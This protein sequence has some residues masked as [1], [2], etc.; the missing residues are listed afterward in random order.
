MAVAAPAVVEQGEASL[1]AGGTEA[2]KL[3]SRGG[4][5]WR[6]RLPVV[7]GVMAFVLAA[8]TVGSAS[9][10]HSKRLLGEGLTPATAQ[11]TPGAGPI[12][13]AWGRRLG[14]GTIE[15][16][17]V[18]VAVSGLSEVVEVAAGPVHSLALA[19]NGTVWAW[20]S[21]LVGALGNG[22]T[23]DST[24]P[25]QVSGL[26]EAVAIAAGEQSSYAVLKNGT[27]MA[28][29]FNLDGA[30]GDGSFEGPESCPPTYPCSRVPL[31]VSGL[32]EV[33]AIAADEGH[34]LALLKNGT[35]KAWG[36]NRWGQLGNGHTENTAAPVAVSGLSEVAGIGVGRLHSLAVLKSGAVEAWGSNEQGQLGDGTTSGPETCLALPCSTKPVAVSGLSE[37]SAVAGGGA[38]SLALLKNHTVKAWGRNESGEL[39]DGTTTNS[40]VPVPV[41]GLSE[42][43]GIAGG[44]GDSFARL[45]SGKAVGWGG[46]SE[47]SLGNGTNTSSS[48]PVAVDGLSEVTDISAG[49]S[50]SGIA[51]G[52]LA[53]LPTVTKVEPTDGP[54]TGGTAVT[55]TGTNF[56]GVTQVKFG[57]TNATSF[58]VN[59]ETSLTATSPAGVGIVDVT[60][61][62]TAGTSGTT[63]A[64]RFAY[65]PT[66]TKA[67]PNNGARMGGTTVTITGTNFTGATAVKFGATNATSFT[68][69]SAS[70]ITAVS[71]AGTGTVDVTVTTPGG[72]SAIGPADQFTYVAAVPTVTKVEP[73]SGPAA[74]GTSVTITGTNF[75]GAT[76]VKFGATNATSFT[77]N[78][79]TSISAVSPPGT[80]TVDVILTTP[81]GTSSTAN[82][83]R[84]TYGVTVTRVEPTS[85]RTAGGTSVTIAGTNFTGAT[86]V[87]FGATNATSFT[88]N[89]ATSITAV[90]PAG[91]GT[92]DV[93]VTTPEGTSAT[94][95]SDHFSY[96]RRFY[97][98]GV[99]AGASTQNVVQFGTIT[100]KSPFWGEIKCNLLV[101]A[102]VWNETER[103]LAS[104]DGWE[105]WGC[106]ATELR[107][108]TFVTA[109]TAVQLIERENTAK[110]RIPEAHRGEKTLPWPAHAVTTPEATSALKIGN[111]EKL[112]LEPVKFLVSAPEELFE[113]PYEGTLEPRIVNGTKN[114]LKPS[115]LEFEGEGGKTGFLKSP[116]IFGGKEP[117]ADLF[118]KGE[119]TL[120]GTSQQLVGAE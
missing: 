105:S 41:S 3:G 39:G 5:R 10:E 119:L 90:S 95:L 33:A 21:N 85:G 77:V 42:A 118:I 50:W 28:W 53:P 56:T 65:V 62:A 1:R 60:V 120:L 22:T 98:N 4:N 99:L 12:P 114:G 57:S 31:K 91:T 55:I 93:T 38:H 9:A 58:T 43:A 61:T 26:S 92:V 27:V 102:P 79:A 108:K 20:G 45:T 59:S 86:A 82:A 24:V 15:S 72:T 11:L 80:G 116:A 67:E 47:G 89:S 54:A 23:T 30:L 84:F 46:N 40:S 32:S 101:G 109:E 97:L 7:V 113:V 68:V 73:N 103:G 17:N 111:T 44:E 81:E 18:P 51:I 35:V 14:S 70:S 25:V 110:V 96:A 83:D 29:G 100:M 36:V 69:N 16:S 66:V 94:S 75:T 106:H 76:A 74:G 52:V 71:P 34:V 115:H 64:D 117:E 6:R 19:K 13:V 63:A 8:F 104:V 2:P 87:K 48:V 112:P 107:G 78:S 88:V 49:G 37:V